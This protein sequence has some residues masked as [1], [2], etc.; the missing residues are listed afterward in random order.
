MLMSVSVE[1]ET[2]IARE[3]RLDKT[4]EKFV[5]QREWLV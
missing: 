3:P 5:R 4:S 1:Y 2:Q